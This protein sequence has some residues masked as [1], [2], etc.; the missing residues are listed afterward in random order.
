[1]GIKDVTEVC[2]A[3]EHVDH[4]ASA[5]CPLI[6]NQ[7]SLI[8]FYKYIE[9]L[10]PIETLFAKWRAAG[11][12]QLVWYRLKGLKAGGLIAD[13]CNFLGIRADG[14]KMKDRML[15]IGGNLL[16]FKLA[17]NQMKE[18]SDS[19]TA[20]HA[21]AEEQTSYRQPFFIDPPAAAELRRNSR[22]NASIFAQLREGTFGRWSS[23]MPLLAPET[24]EDDFALIAERLDVQ[25]TPKNRISAAGSA[26]RFVLTP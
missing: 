14:L 21:P 6:R 20:L 17:W 25:V 26:N 2:Y 22:Y 5:L 1:M 4:A 10:T 18:R 9:R 8:E 3:R 24:L 19:N 7:L 12:V 11:D 23:A 16:R 15:N 13:F